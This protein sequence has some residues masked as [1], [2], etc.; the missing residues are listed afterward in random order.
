VK[1]GEQNCIK[2]DIKIPRKGYKVY[3][4]D[5]KLH[6]QKTKGKISE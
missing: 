5:R 6:K 3:N 4:K 2:Q 1:E